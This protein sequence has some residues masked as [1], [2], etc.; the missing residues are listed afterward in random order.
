MLQY[1]RWANDT[2]GLYRTYRFSGRF[3]AQISLSSIFPTSSNHP[4]FFSQKSMI[5]EIRTSKFY[6]ASVPTYQFTDVCP[7][8]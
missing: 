7:F 4:K 1:K 6:S 5:R 8:V 2:K 3:Q